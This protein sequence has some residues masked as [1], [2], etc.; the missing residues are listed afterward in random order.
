MTYRY[1]L[2]NESIN[3]GCEQIRSFIESAEISNADRIKI[4]L[5]IEET[6]LQYQERFGDGIDFSLNLY[7]I[8]GAYKID[9]RV[10][11]VRFNPFSDANDE[12]Q[13]LNEKNPVAAPASGKQLRIH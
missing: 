6:L 4:P 5:L 3:C 12:T 10:N 1:P 11:C 9:L 2:T 8:L 13:L 7:T